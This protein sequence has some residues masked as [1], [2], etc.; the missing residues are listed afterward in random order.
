[1]SEQRR[2]HGMTAACMLDDCP[3]PHTGEREPEP[4]AAQVPPDVAAVLGQMGERFGYAIQPLVDLLRARDEVL[5]LLAPRAVA[6]QQSLTE[7]LAMLDAHAVRPNWAAEVRTLETARALL[8]D[9]PADRED[10]PR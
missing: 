9:Q 4:E 2:A 7:V 8:A 6:L 1:M 10:P 5:A 3:G